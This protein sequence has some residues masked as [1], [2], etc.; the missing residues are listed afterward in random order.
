M[1]Y[2]LRLHL[3][4]CLI[5]GCI[6][7]LAFWIRVQGVE[8]LPDGHL[9]ETDAYFYYWQAQLISEHGHLP[10][11]DMHRWL[12]IGRDLGQ[13][14]NLYGYVLAYTHKAMAVVF[15]NVTL[16]HVSV[17]MPVLCFCIGLG[18]LY[19]FLYHTYGLIFQLLLACFW[20][21]SLAA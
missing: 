17:Y 2:N 3:F 10:A 1:S 16:Y 11:R 5:F 8:R 4:S 15:P 6:L 14:L 7:L 21:P 13:T 19:I 20:Q 12:P 9:T 18:A